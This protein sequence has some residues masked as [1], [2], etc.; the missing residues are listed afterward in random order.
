MAFIF[1]A[2]P[3]SPTANS[4]ATVAQANDWHSSQ[5]FGAAW[6]EV[7]EKEKALVTATGLIVNVMAL[8]GWAGWPVSTS[9]ALPMPRSGIW[10]RNGGVISPYVNPPEL[11]NATAE[12]ALR[13]VQAGA[14]PDAPSDNPAGI[15][16]LVAG[17]VELVFDTAAQSG[18]LLDIPEGIWLMISFLA[19]NAGG[20][21]GTISFPLSRV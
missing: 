20:R 19:V 16:E 14:L 5:L 7:E 12:Y 6:D 10:G 3:G 1:N 17:P 15:K 21:P 8:I 11:I 9:Q 4:F 13:L 18:P 2:T